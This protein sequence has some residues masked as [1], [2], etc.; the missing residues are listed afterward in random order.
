VSVFA[1]SRGGS[2]NS[3]GQAA[4]GIRAK[5]L[6]AEL[7]V[8]CTFTQNE[9]VGGTRMGLRGGADVFSREGAASRAT[10]RVHG[11]QGPRVKSR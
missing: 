4:G 3:A 1:C 10:S 8:V 9:R 7:D 2:V 6:P 11:R 5:P